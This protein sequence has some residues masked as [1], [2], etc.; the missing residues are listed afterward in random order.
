MVSAMPRRRRLARMARLEYALSARTRPRPGPRTPAPAPVDPDAV[1]H[2][3]EHDAVV[4][5]AG[6]DD[7]RDGAAP[8]VGVEVDLGG[9]PA[10]GPSQRFSIMVSVGVPVT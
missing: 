4:T 10:A 5:L 3:S 2:G 6:I 1:E 9:Q 7:P 8:Q